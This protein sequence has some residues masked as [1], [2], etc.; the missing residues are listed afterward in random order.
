MTVQK[1]FLIVVNYYVI[2]FTTAAVKDSSTVCTELII[3]LT[4]FAQYIQF[5]T[6]FPISQLQIF[7]GTYAGSK[8]VQKIVLTLLVL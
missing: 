1:T 7:M 4:C 8:R 6:L 2:D 5:L 3:V